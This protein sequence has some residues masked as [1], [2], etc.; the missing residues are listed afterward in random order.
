MFER[1]WT[2]ACT[3]EKF[4]G[5]LSRE[6]KAC[7]SDPMEDKAMLKAVHDVL[8]EHYKAWYSMFV[9]Y[10]ALGNMDPYHMTLNPYTSFLDDCQIPDAESASCKRSNLDTIFIVCNY[11]VGTPLSMYGHEG[12]SQEA[13]ALVLRPGLTVS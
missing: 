11:E 1:D 8:L 13:T 4:T 5:M 3:K 6:N 2:R 7:K 9:Y 12:D 10:S